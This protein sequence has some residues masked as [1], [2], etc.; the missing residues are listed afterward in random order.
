MLQ[1]DPRTCDDFHF[2]YPFLPPSPLARYRMILIILI[3]AFQDCSN[4]R[5]EAAFIPS[6]EHPKIRAFLFL[7]FSDVS[8]NVQTEA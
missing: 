7:A 2:I 1:T 6:D 8:Q 5:K 3:F 4:P